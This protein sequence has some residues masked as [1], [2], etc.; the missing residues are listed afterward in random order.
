MNGRCAESSAL[1]TAMLR[2]LQPPACPPGQGPSRPVMPGLLLRP[3]ILS[4]VRRKG[5]GHSPTVLSLWAGCLH[6]V[7]NSSLN[8]THHHLTV[9]WV[10]D[11]VHPTGWFWLQVSLEA[12]EERSAGAAVWYEGSTRA[13]GDSSRSC[14]WE[15]QSLPCGLSTGF[16]RVLTTWWLAAPKGAIRESQ[17]EATVPFMT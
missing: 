15:A 4:I 3:C 2:P 12:V 10:G 7:T 8:D 14:G 9:L 17:V 13:G 5:S 1:D 6:R 11:L 16:S